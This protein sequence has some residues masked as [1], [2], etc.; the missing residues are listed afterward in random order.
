MLNEGWSPRPVLTCNPNHSNGDRTLYAAVDT[1]RF[2]PALPGSTGMDSALS[3]IR[4]PGLNNWD[5][6]V[7]KRIPVGHS[8]SRYLQ[9][10]LEF[11]NISNHTP[12]Q[13]WEIRVDSVLK[14]DRAAKRELNNASHEEVPRSAASA[15]HDRLES[16]H[17]R[18]S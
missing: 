14:F 15:N 2:Q 13:V 5:A 4:G 16:T 9:L 3:P 11:Y 8:E 18:H 7:Y 12:A 1:S 6:S 17:S 10:R